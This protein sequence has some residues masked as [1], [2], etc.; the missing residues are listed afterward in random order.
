[1]VDDRRVEGV[2]DGGLSVRSVGICGGV[3]GMED[4]IR[5]VKG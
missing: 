4:C 2:E 1:M 3:G 5:E